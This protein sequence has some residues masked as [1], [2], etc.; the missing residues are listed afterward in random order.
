MPAQ[1]SKRRYEVEMKLPR[2]VGAALALVLLTVPLLA[3]DP[4]GAN[5]PIKPLGDDGHVLNFDFETGDLRDWTV[6]GDA[7]A[8][9]PIRGDTVSKRRSD[10]KS[11]HQGEYWV[12]GYE[13]SGDDATGTLTSAPFKIT[14]RWASFLVGGG[15]WQELRVELCRAD[16]NLTYYTFN[17]GREDE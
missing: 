17:G 9:Q 12:G 13:T 15:A 3:A 16:N 10:Q 7:F 1:L 8:K 2:T 4:A 6:Q 5:A 11:N 14:Q